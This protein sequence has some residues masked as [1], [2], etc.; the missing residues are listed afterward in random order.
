MADVD[1]A[2]QQISRLGITPTYTAIDATDTYFAPWMDGRLIL[3]FKNTNG[4]ISTVTF[5]VQQTVDGL[6]ITDPTVT[7]PA[8]T[9]DKFIGPIP[10]AYKILSGVDANLVKFSQN[11]ATGVTVA[12]LVA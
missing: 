4:S 10:F 8:T 12:A 1:L 7:I 5:D 3:H 2:V 11:V 6:A 9:G